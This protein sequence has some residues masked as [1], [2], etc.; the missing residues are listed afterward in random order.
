MIMKSL[1]LV[2]GILIG[3]IFCFFSNKIDLVSK[4]MDYIVKLN[5]D[6]KISNEYGNVIVIPKGSALRY[7]SQYEGSGNFALYITMMDLSIYEK[8]D[9]GHAT[10]FVADEQ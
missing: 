6:I 1:L 5:K 8:L 10:Y 3:F 9:N 4:K 7:K 2:I